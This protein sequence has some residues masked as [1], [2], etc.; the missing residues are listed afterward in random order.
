MDSFNQP[1]ASNDLADAIARHLS[2]YPYDIRRVRKLMRHFRASATDMEL[3]INR[4]AAPLTLRVDPENTGD[5]VLLHFLRYPGDLV[6][7]RRIMRQLHAS[8][9]EVQD[10]LTKLA[11]YVADGRGEMVDASGD[12][13]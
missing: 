5:K 7:I 1:S 4:I 9:R 2:Q 10:A 8:A 6:D 3:A 12:K 13:E 11:A